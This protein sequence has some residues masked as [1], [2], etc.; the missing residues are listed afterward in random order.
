MQKGITAALAALVF[1]AGIGVG[2]SAKLRPVPSMYQGKDNKEAAKAL[3]EVALVQ[4]GK[5]SWER[6]GVGRVYYLGGFKAEGQ[7]IFDALLAGEHED[8]DVY[9]IARVYQ[10]AGEWEKARVLFEQHLARNPEEAKDLAEIGAYYYMQGDR[11]KAEQ[12]FSKS[13]AVEGDEVWSTL[14]AAGAYLGVRP[15]L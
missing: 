6:I 7:K 13:F 10:Q 8:S 11:A 2:Y 14:S 3:L 4:A 5:G 15:N 1:T 12:L 9:R